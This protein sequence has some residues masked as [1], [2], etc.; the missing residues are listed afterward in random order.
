MPIVEGAS[1]PS[2]DLKDFPDTELK[3]NQ[4]VI[5][6]DDGNPVILETTGDD[7]P[8]VTTKQA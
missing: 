7:D 6:D 4:K 2:C 8:R 5:C 1:N 3:D